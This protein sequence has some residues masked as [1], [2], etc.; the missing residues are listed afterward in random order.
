[1]VDI[2]VKKM[3]EV[4]AGYS[5][6]IKG[7]QLVLLQFEPAGFPLAREVYRLAL[8]AGAY[9]LVRVVRLRYRPTG[10]GQ[11][12]RPAVCAGKRER[13]RPVGSGPGETCHGQ[14]GA[15]TAV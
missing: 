13:E 7:Q 2:N 8:E 1:M 12:R 9:P 4:I 11:H 5:L 15:K 6:A 3:A 14:P 10:D